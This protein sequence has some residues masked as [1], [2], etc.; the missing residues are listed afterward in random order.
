[1]RLDHGPAVEQ[2]CVQ[3]RG[4][5]SHRVRRASDHICQGV[6]LS[7]RVAVSL[8]L[9]AEAAACCSPSRFLCSTAGLIDKFV[10][11]KLPVSLCGCAVVR[12][13]ELWLRG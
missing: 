11:S 9:A 13:F 8:P 4:P 10:E 5:R 3:V 2:V 12:F 1:M 7:S 6:P